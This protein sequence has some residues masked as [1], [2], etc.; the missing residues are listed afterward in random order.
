MRVTTGPAAERGRRREV[1]GGVGDEDAVVQL[2]TQAEEI[3]ARRR[4]P[5]VV[6]VAPALRAVAVH[7]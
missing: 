1:A 7:S 3:A 5:E 6:R 4:G 2:R